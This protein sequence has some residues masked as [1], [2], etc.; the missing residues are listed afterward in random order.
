MNQAGADAW[1]VVED[2]AGPEHARRYRITRGQTVLSWRELLE[3]LNTRDDF[4][5]FFC[6]LLRRIPFEAYYWETPPVT[7]ESQGLG[8]EFVAV[9]A[10]ALARLNPDPMPFRGQ[11]DAAAPHQEVIVFDNLG[12]DALLVAPVGIGPTDAY[13]HLAAFMHHAPHSQQQHFWQ[14]AAAA[15][16]TRL[17]ESPIWLSTAGL[18]VAWLHL[19]LDTRPK[20]YSYAPYRT[21]PRPSCR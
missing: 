11:F 15:L 4:R 19:R 13:A 12:G 2:E 21:F 3:L 1:Q 20:Y 14:T 18:G 17:G 6:R 9:D 10:P 8:F 16:R 5:H 7:S